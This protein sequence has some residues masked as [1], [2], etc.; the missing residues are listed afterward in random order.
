MDKDP[1]VTRLP[2]GRAQ[3]ALDV[4]EWAGRRARMRDKDRRTA[5]GKQGATKRPTRPVSAVRRR[6]R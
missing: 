3:G 1:Q 5:D 2:P 6:S 4:A